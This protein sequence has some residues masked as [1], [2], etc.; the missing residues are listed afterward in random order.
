M[1]KHLQFD[2]FVAEIGLFLSCF[3]TGIKSAHTFYKTYVAKMWCAPVSK[4]PPSRCSET[5]NPFAVSILDLQ[6]A[7]QESDYEGQHILTLY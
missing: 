2:S 4:H 1:F 7:N 3:S 5:I 6:P